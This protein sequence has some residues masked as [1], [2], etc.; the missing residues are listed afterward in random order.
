MKVIQ[1]LKAFSS[2]QAMLM[3]GTS[4]AF[5]TNAVACDYMWYEHWHVIEQLDASMLA[6]LHSVKL[7][8]CKGL[9]QTMS[10]TLPTK[11]VCIAQVY[12]CTERY[13]CTSQDLGKCY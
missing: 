6:S 2:W 5:H 3:Q 10:S 13:V 9:S 4:S 12:T 1:V 7:L 8:H 11:K